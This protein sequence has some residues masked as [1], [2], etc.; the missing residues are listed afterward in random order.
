MSPVAS[1]DLYSLFLTPLSF[2]LVE[3]YLSSFSLRGSHVGRCATVLRNLVAHRLLIGRRPLRD[4]HVDVARPLR[5]S[6]P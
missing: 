1:P 5:D 6:T 4:S 3:N 2:S